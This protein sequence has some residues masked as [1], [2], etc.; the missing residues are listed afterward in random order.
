MHCIA[1]TRIEHSPYRVSCD[2]NLEDADATVLK[3]TENLLLQI[4]GQ[5]VQPLWT[6][7]GYAIPNHNSQTR[8]LYVAV[9]ERYL[10]HGFGM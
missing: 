3:H 6:E 8:L 4:D 10:H 7:I 1:K 2:S 9:F 5:L